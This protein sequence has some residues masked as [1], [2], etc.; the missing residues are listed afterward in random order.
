MLLNVVAV[1]VS[2]RTGAG[3]SSISGGIE[4]MEQ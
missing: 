1:A 4:Y 2:G 3:V